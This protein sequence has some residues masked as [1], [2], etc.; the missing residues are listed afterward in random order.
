[1]N[2]EEINLPPTAQS[3]SPVL[4]LMVECRLVFDNIGIN[5]FTES[6]FIFVKL[7]QG[8]GKDRQGMVLKAKGFKAETL[9]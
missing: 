9:A 6:I 7:R 5:V 8:S 4:V 1:M 3:P 2:Y